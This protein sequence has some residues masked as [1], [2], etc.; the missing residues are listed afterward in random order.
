MGG[1]TRWGEGELRYSTST[2]LGSFQ[3]VMEVRWRNYFS[4]FCV[5]L[6]LVM[7]AD[8]GHQ[9]LNVQPDVEHQNFIIPSVSG[10]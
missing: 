10:H 8:W 4:N 9:N 1:R 7:S 2:F 3:P 5:E 6:H